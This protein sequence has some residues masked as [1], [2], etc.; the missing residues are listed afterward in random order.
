MTVKDISKYNPDELIWYLKQMMRIRKFEEKYM[1]LLM[2]DIAKGASHLYIGQE[3]VAV[4]ACAAIRK[5]DYITSTH[6]GHGHCIAKGADLKFM[7]AELL[8]KATGYCKGKGGSM[9]VADVTSGNLGA[10]G[11][12]G[13]N[14]PIATGAALSIKMRK[15]D[16]VVLCF[17]GDG[18]ANTGA[19]HES[20]NMA[21]IWRLPVVYICENNLYGMSVSVKRAFPFEDIAERA[22]GY[23]IPGVIAD[24]M[25]VLDVKE[26]VEEAVKRARK[27]EGPTLVECKTYRYY[28]HSLSDPRKYRTREEE[29]IWRAKD[30]IRIFSKKLL[31][32]GILTKDKLRALEEEVQREVDEAESFALSSPYP[33]I[34]SL[35][36]DVYTEFYE[37]PAASIKNLSTA[38]KMNLKMRKITYRQALNEALREEMLRDESVFVMGEDVGIYGGA[39]GV[40]RGLYDEFGPERVRDTPI[41]EAAIAGAAAGAAMT[42]MRPV[43]EIMYIDFITLAMDQIVNIAAKSRYMFGGKLKVPV[44][45]RTQSGAGRG[46]AAHHSGSWEA[47]FIH[48]PGILVVT[49]STP[50]DAKGLLKTCIRDDNPILFI[51]HK[52][53]Y[54]VEGEV[55]EGEYT[56]PL[57]VADVKRPGKDVTIIAY[58]RMVHFALEA[59]EELAKEGIDAEVIDP[60]TLKPLDV[61]TIVSSVKKTH[62]AIVVHEACKTCGFG[63]EI[64]ALIMEKAFD[65]LDAPIMRVAGA[66][67]PIPMSPTL[68][69]EAIPSKEKI[70]EAVKKII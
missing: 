65:Y 19:F 1:D 69:A 9:H 57:G 8:G 55:P 48:A 47:W 18:A 63:A 17:F 60:R 23:N 7:M 3:A 34:E 49:P 56:V 50:F 40:T 21:A 30:P 37:D 39:Y 16:Q 31:D 10:T 20:L 64:A 27:G 14:I 11:I 46:I 22:K 45:Y 13:S 68:E 67:V 52:M 42:G 44:V 58:S 43:A 70:I 25:D 38:K 66:D 54:N 62:R 4:G 5:E 28:G 61:D 24:G 53:L 35:Y 6:R 15:K 59:A 51:E 32:T 2:R 29:E 12:V 26:T 33:P 36:E 41:S